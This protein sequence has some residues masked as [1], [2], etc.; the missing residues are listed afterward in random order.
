MS[1]SEYAVTGGDRTT[2]QVN[3]NVQTGKDNI[4]GN[5]TVKSSTTTTTTDSNQ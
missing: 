4:F 3:V 5:P 1:F 2:D